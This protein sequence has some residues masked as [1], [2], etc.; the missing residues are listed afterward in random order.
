MPCFII[1][2]NIDE[3]G[4][5]SCNVSKAVSSFTYSFP[6]IWVALFLKASTASLYWFTIFILDKSGAT[7][8]NTVNLNNG[9]STICNTHKYN[10]KNIANGSFD[11]QVAKMNNNSESEIIIGIPEITVAF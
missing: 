3:K 1:Y 10:V 7:D 6:F 2:L 9:Y 5:I 11:F 8:I 4:R